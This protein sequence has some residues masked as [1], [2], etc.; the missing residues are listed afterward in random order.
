MKAM[1]HFIDNM[2]LI[3]TKQ[4]TFV[5]VL[6]E[7]NKAKIFDTRTFKPIQEIKFKSDY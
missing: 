6:F 7:N 1:E 5:M 3:K 2:T 4:R